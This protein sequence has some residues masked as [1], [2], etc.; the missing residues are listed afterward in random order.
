METGTLMKK[1]RGFARARKSLAK[2]LA[3]AVLAASIFTAGKAKADDPPTPP[4]SAGT[5]FLGGARISTSRGLS[6]DPFT[7]TLHYSGLSYGLGDEDFSL[8]YDG[9][10]VKVL[11]HLKNLDLSDLSRIVDLLNFGRAL[12]ESIGINAPGNY[13]LE[14][15]GDLEAFGEGYGRALGR[16][17]GGLYSTELGLSAYILARGRAYVDTRLD[18][19]NWDLPTRLNG[20]LHAGF[21]AQMRS[22]ESLGVEAQR[23]DGPLRLGYGIMG[24]R[25]MQFD[26]GGSIDANLNAGLFSGF[27]AGATA[28]YWSRRARGYDVLPYLVLVSDQGPLRVSANAGVDFRREEDRSSTDHR[29]VQR[30]QG[31]GPDVSQSSVTNSTAFSGIP[32]LGVAVAPRGQEHIFPVLSL[33]TLDSVHGRGTLGVRAGRLLTSASVSSDLS[34]RSETFVVLRGNVGAQQY[35]DYLFETDSAQAGFFPS[36][37]SRM[38]RVRQAFLTSSDATMLRSSLDYDPRFR[39]LTSENGVA[40]SRKRFFV[41][42]GVRLFGGDSFGAGVY[43]AIGTRCFFT[44]QSYSATVTGGQNVQTLMLSIGGFIP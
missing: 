15:R 21:S 41:E 18:Y 34:A 22:S 43:N 3:G 36:Y 38:L 42:S 11:D 19:D 7:Q 10:D 17:D 9:Q 20:D 1:D 31:A 12:R 16:Y 25:F 32:V 8:R 30:G 28:D 44:T 13:H 5:S 40:F 14:L 33:S 4:A 29:S 23:L 39:E 35:G 27:D 6:F 24:R 37:R 26:A 2:A